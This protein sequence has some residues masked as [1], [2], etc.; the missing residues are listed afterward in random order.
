MLRHQMRP[1]EV[2]ERLVE[3]TDVRAAQ[4]RAIAATMHP[5]TERVKGAPRDRSRDHRDLW[6]SAHRRLTATG[7]FRLQRRLVAGGIDAFEAMVRAY[8]YFATTYDPDCG[9][10]LSRLLKDVFTPLREG[11]D[12]RLS[13]CAKCGIVHLTHEEKSGI[14]ECPVCVLSRAGKYGQRRPRPDR[15]DPVPFR[16]YGGWGGAGGGGWQSTTVP[17]GQSRA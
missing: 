3:F 9:V 14:I 17:A 5:K 7:I 16:P 15:L 10:S 1:T 8:D 13:H 12:T 11:C 6:G 2:E 4:L